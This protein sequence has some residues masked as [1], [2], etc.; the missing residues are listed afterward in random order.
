MAALASG[1][2]LSDDAIR[3]DVIYQLEWEPQLAD[4]DIGVA[5]SNG[6]VTLTGTVP[7][8]W[9]KQEVERAAKRVYGVRAVANDIQLNLTSKRTDPE[10]ARDAVRELE[11]HILIPSDKIKVTVR[12][13]WVTLEGEV[14]WQFQRKLAESTIRKLEGVAGIIN[15]IA[16]KTNAPPQKIKEKIEEALR[17]SA[18]LDARRLS[19]ETDG[20]KV[21]LR[22]TV[23][24]WNE[25]E[26]AERA[27]W[28][29]PGVTEVENLIE[30]VP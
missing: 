20:S 26:E 8:L 6:V 7:N 29:A 22:G 5:V 27:A 13:G 10:I 25:R 16:I 9:I 17:R 1:T 14:R 23:R 12:D 4:S 11:S 3:R 2:K 24:S 15:N 18:E 21:I 30:V 28:A 19:V